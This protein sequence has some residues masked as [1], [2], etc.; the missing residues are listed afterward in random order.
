MRTLQDFMYRNHESMVSGTSIGQLS[1]QTL[2]SDAV[3]SIT[4][5]PT[6][7]IYFVMGFQLLPVVQEV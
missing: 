4:I 2:F 3:G 1:G 7:I 6:Y 5:L